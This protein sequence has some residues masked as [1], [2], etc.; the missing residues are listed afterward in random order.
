M[1]LIWF[2]GAPNRLRTP[3][4][5]NVDSSEKMTFSRSLASLLIFTSVFEHLCIDPYELLNSLDAL[6]IDE[7]GLS[8]KCLWMFSFSFSSID[9]LPDLSESNTDPVFLNLFNRFHMVF[10]CGIGFPPHVSQIPIFPL[11]IITQ[12]ADLGP[13]QKS[14]HN[15]M[16][17]VVYVKTKFHK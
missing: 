16:N 11:I 7:V 4:K 8:S 6:L 13:F 15:L 10:S 2:F 1:G 12:Q 14:R 9:G 3:S 17:N 5:R